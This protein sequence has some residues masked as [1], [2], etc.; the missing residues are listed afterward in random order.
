M[1][2]QW[3]YGGYGDPNAVPFDPPKLVWMD[4]CESAGSARENY[5]NQLPYDGE[6]AE[7]MDTGWADCWGIKYESGYQGV[8]VGH[9]GFGYMYQ[10][11]TT[12]PAYTWTAYRLSLWRNIFTNGENL[13]TAIYHAV[14]GAPRTMSG[15]QNP[16]SRV[17]DA[18][19]GS[20]SF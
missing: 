16:Q 7:I 2:Y 9:D 4:N 15:S 5:P 6:P 8:F 19:D 13:T 17:R 12:N 20:T 11:D 14:D 1:I 10:D 3:N 18:G